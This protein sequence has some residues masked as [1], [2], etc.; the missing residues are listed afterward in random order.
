MKKLIIVAFIV[1]FTSC[2]E[3]PV[4]KTIEGKGVQVELLF[5]KDGIKVYRFWDGIDFH[6][7]TNRGETITTKVRYKNTRYEENIQE[8]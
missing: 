3:K 8:N 7:F 1:T 4:S 6:Y 2:L 5:E